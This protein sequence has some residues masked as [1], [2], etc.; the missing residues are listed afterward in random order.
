MG[1]LLYTKNGVYMKIYSLE[2]DNVCLRDRN[3]RY[4]K[5]VFKGT[6][7]RIPYA[8]R[9]IDYYN[10]LSY[11]AYLDIHDD[12]FA[13]RNRIIRK[14][15]LSFLN[16]IYPSEKLEFINHFKDITKFPNLNAVSINIENEFINSINRAARDLGKPEYQVIAAGYD[17][18]CSVGKRTALPGSDLDKA[19]IIIRGSSNID[20][21]TTV[22][23]R[24]K[25]KL[26]EGT[27]QRILSYNHDTSFPSVMTLNQVRSTMRGITTITDGMQFDSYK[28]KENVDSE[29]I[30]LIKAAEF[31][32]LLAGQLPK[33]KYDDNDYVLNKESVKNFAYFIESV[34]D[35]KKVMS[36]PEFLKLISEISHTQ[37]YNYSN[38]AQITAMKNAIYE[39]REQKTKMIR[40]RK[41]EQEFNSWT[42]DKQ[43]D[44]IK[45]LIQYSCEDQEE[46]MEYFNNDRNVKEIYKPLLGLLCYGDA[47]RRI[48]PEFI[49]ESD[50]VKIYLSK[51]NPVILYQGYA[52]NVLWIE[53]ASKEII[54]D[55][56]LHIDKLR[57]IDLFKT[58]NCVQAPFITGK[59]LPEN[60]G[61]INF[62]TG[63]GRRIIERIL[64]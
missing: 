37:F 59:S 21:D 63:G 31:N 64:R 10:L 24:F 52:P 51:D 33:R 15:N 9:G 6:P 7:Q 45:A 1:F 42:T 60:F 40:R 43:F 30:D 61:Y 58:I 38:V 20:S 28:M 16:R 29:Y 5:S 22:V 8:S 2:Y 14:A 53:S 13:P 17:E 50:R 57:K 39:G 27:D 44:F 23:N 11:G 19:F 54:E 55:V 26:W 36:S 3:I 41:L 49:I 12:A 18:T 35:G 34:R 62:S 4:P 47:S 46:F 56:L 32:I 48:N 25:A